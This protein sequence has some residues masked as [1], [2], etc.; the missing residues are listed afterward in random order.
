MSILSYA[1]RLYQ[2]PMSIIGVTFGTILL[3]T[4]S[5]LYKTDEIEKAKK[6][7]DNAIKIG[8]FL[9][10]PCSVALIVLSYPIISLIYHYGAFTLEDTLATAE[11]I[12]VF[13]IGLPAFVLSK[14]FMPI[15]YA[16][17][18]TKTPMKITIYT[19]VAN[20]ILN[21]ILMQPLDYVGI[22]LGSSLASWYGVYLSVKHTKKY[23]Y[24]SLTNDLIIFIAKLILS[25]IVS[26][27]AMY[28]A[29]IGISDIFLN[30]GDI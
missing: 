17:Q 11:T 10:L 20:L 8:M 27:G 13:A 19:I 16:H 29:Y 21:L 14:I 1:D 25:C 30:D 3:P 24:F 18:D 28:S 2:L 26:G 5:K 4:L 15:F 12:A 23:G 7:Q 22:A 6:T 9:S